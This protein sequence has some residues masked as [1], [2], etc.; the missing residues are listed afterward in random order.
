M[1]HNVPVVSRAGSDQ[2]LPFQCATSP[3]APTAQTS[4]AAAPQTLRKLSVVPLATD[5]QPLPSKWRMMPRGPTPHA[6]L[7][8]A[9]HTSSFSPCGTGFDQHQPLAVQTGCRPGATTAPS[10]WTASLT[11]AFS[12]GASTTFMS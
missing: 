10:P 9:A 12:K 8:L 7:A 1:H 4:F 3:L 11:G 5:V 6:S 2:L